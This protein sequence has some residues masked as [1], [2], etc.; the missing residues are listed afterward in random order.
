M[1]ANREGEAGGYF[2]P[3]RSIPVDLAQVDRTPGCSG[4][5]AALDACWAGGRAG[6]AGSAFDVEHRQAVVQGDSRQAQV[7]GDLHHGFVLARIQSAI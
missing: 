1:R 7:A 2:T 5:P 3:Q 4:I 6:P